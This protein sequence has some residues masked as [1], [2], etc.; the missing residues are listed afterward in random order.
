MTI[1]VTSTTKIVHLDGIPCRIWEGCTD[2]GIPVHTYIARISVDAG[3]PSEAFA[4]FERELKAQRVPSPEV[5][6]IPLRLI[7]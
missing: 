3:L 7:L 2:T 4:Q 1:T 5:A 6:A